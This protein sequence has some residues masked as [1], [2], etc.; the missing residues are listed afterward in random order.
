MHGIKTKPISISFGHR[1]TRKDPYRAYQHPWIST[2]T[3]I[4]NLNSNVCMRRKEIE[5]LWIILEFVIF[6]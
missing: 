4:I 5:I 2:L 3:L 6:E 1:G